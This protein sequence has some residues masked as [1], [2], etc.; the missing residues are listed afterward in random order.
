MSRPGEKSI[1]NEELRILRL[2][3]ERQPI[4]AAAVAQ[5]LKTK[6]GKARTTVL[7][8]VERLRKKGYLKRRKVDGVYEYS[9]RE[10]ASRV[11]DSLVKAFVDRALDGSVMPFLSYMA[12]ETELSNEEFSELERLVDH[13]RKD[14]NS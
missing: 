3:A 2:I 7:T 9:M 14:R 4:P 10:D 8:V 12:R 6:E 11:Q 5:E 1:G 13:L